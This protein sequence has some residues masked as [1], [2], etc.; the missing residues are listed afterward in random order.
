MGQEAEWHANDRFCSK[1]LLKDNLYDVAS[2]YKHAQL[3]LRVCHQPPAR[4]WWQDNLSCRQWPFSQS[5][6]LVPDSET[7]GTT[8]I[9][10]WHPTTFR[11]QTLSKISVLVHYPCVG[12]WGRPSSF[13]LQLLQ[14]YRAGRHQIYVFT[15]CTCV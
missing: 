14:L 10:G 6:F 7:S 9:G 15:L 13:D 11:R 5:G 12:L 8:K 4:C 1:K 2:A 3:D